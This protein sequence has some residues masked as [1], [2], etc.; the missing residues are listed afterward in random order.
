MRFLERGVIVSAVVFVANRKLWIKPLKFGNE[1]PDCH[2]I[3]TVV[4]GRSWLKFCGLFASA[5]GAQGEESDDASLLFG[6]VN[7]RPTA[8]A[9]SHSIILAVLH[10]L[11]QAG[12]I[13]GFRVVTITSGLAA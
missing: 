2:L 3:R 5:S 8:S 1:F 11:S 6:C 12:A 9:V 7:R 4:V 13:T 10:A